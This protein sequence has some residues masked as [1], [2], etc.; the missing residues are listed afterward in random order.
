MAFNPQIIPRTDF[1][2]NIGVGVSIPFTNGAVFTPTYTS[3]A[4]TKYN[5]LN[6]LVTEP[7]ER[8]DNPTFGFG[9]RKYLFIQIE[10][11]SLDYLQDDLSSIITEYFPQITLNEVRTTPNPDNQTITVQIYYSL[12]NQSINDQLEI[13][14]G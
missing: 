13:T 1:Y 6:F 2:P 8:F 5:L 11:D 4:A 10:Q 3:Q 12:K 7:G 14:F 9:L